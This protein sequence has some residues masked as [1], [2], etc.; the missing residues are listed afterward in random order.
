MSEILANKLSPSTGT[1]VQIGDSGDTITVP[2]GAGLTVTDEVKTNKISP[3]SGTA[4]TLGDS[5]DTFTIPAG[6]TITNSGTAT[7]FGGTNAGAFHVYKATFSMANAADTLIT[8]FSEIFDL[9]SWFASDKYTPQEAGK[10][11]FFYSMRADNIGTTARMQILIKKNGSGLG[12]SIGETNIVSSSYPSVSQSYIVDMNG[13]SDYIE[14]SGYQNSGGSAA[15]FD[16]FL[17]GYKLIT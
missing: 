7:G 4:F 3:S 8:G 2:T 11:V 12:N 13:S 5:G 15:I 9:D 1:A 16:L 10:Y 17:M 6:A 14:L